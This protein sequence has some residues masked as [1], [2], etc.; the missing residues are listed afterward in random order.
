MQ[1]KVSFFK[2]I[3]AYLIDYFVIT[4]LLTI[5]TIGT[6]VDDSFTNE[7]TDLMNSYVN[8]EISIEEYN[9]KVYDINYRLQKSSILS[10]V[11]SF[12]VMFGYY[13]VFAYLNKGQTLGKK[14]FKIRVVSTDDKVSLKGMIIRNIIIYGFITKLYNIIFVN[15][16]DVNM[17]NSV[18]SILS[19]IMSLF[20][21]VSFMMVLYRKDGRGLHD[22]IARTNVVGEVR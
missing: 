12:V 19:Y 4:I 1:V 6:P 18:Y 5:V 13:I 3:G 21:I 16:F 20:V 7:T 8:E 15:L 17:F 14:L 11:I 2:R 9:D 22:I 10:N